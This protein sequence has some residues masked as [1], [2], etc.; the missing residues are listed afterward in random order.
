[1]QKEFAF[2]ETVW[3]IRGKG[4]IT[5]SKLTGKTMVALG[6]SLFYGH[7]LGTEHTWLAL[8]AKQHDMTVFNHGVNGNTMAYV[9]GA[10]EPMCRR[11]RD[12]EDA[13][14]V[15][16]LGGANDR[17]QNVPMGPFDSHDEKTFIGALRILIEGLIEKYPK[18]RILFMTNYNR[19][20]KNDIGLSDRDYV[21]AML[22]ITAEY[23]IPCFDNYR[24]L[25]ISFQNPAHSAWMDEGVVREGKPN[26]HFSAEAYEWMLPKYEQ[27]ILDL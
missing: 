14:Y 10:S 9:E 16:V 23:S 5:M 22:A 7:K 3:Y 8:L 27:L 18:A 6:D 2:P 12:M 21:D 17:N 24:R 26:L 1:M 19:R 4:V 11:F 25:G 20:P 15:V 13:D